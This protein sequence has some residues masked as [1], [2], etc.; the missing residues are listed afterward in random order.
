M[1][2]LTGAASP[3]EN[4]LRATTHGSS[5]EDLLHLRMKHLNR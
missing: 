5:R 4:W 3:D 2:I 1:I